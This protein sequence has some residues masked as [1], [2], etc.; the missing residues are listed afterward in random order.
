MQFPEIA[1]AFFTAPLLFFLWFN[2]TLLFT[3]CQGLFENLCNKSYLFLHF[4]SA[5]IAF[6]HFYDI[7]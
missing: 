4:I 5:I 2:Y 7:L 6:S 1:L 3:V